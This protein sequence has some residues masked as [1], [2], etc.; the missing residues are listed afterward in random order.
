[1][2][3]QIIRAVLD[4]EL[5]ML[6]PDSIDHLWPT[7]MSKW[8]TRQQQQVKRQIIH[9]SLAV[10]MLVLIAAFLVS[11]QLRAAAMST[12]SQLIS[13]ANQPGQP[14]VYTPSPPFTVWQPGNSNDLELVQTAYNHGTAI[15][16]GINAS[17][18]ISILFTE[19]DKSWDLSQTAI[20]LIYRTKGGN[21]IWLYERAVL[22]GEQLSLGESITVNDQLASLEVNG[23]NATLTWL[24]NDTKIVLRGAANEREM[25]LQL[26]KSLVV[27]STPAYEVTSGTEG[28][29]EVASVVEVKQGDPGPNATIWSDEPM[30]VTDVPGQQYHGRLVVEVWT[31]GSTLFYGSDEDG[32][33]PNAEFFNR[34]I[35]SLLEYSE[36]TIITDTPW[37]DE[38]VLGEVPEQSYLGRVVVEV[39]DEHIS[40]AITGTEPISTLAQRGIAKIEQIQGGSGRNPP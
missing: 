24:T 35:A 2:S 13:I 31:Q 28:G 34:A 20:L 15:P 11:P 21:E 18:K 27:T 32:N 6:L 33:P 16:Q 37:T 9:R 14:V 30:L 10:T 40:I 38:P 8:T 7:V 23:Q 25:L 19:I 36:E 12:F 3:T 29:T 22:P 39:W 17:D 4:E 5:A 1:M 26:A